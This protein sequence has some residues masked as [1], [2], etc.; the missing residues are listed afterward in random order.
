[1]HPI[2]INIKGDVNGHQLRCDFA[3]IRRL[4]ARVEYLPVCSGGKPENT[5]ETE[6]RKASRTEQPEPLLPLHASQSRHQAMHHRA[7]TMRQ[8]RR[9]RRLNLLIL[10][11]AAS[12]RCLSLRNGL[13]LQAH[14]L[15]KGA[16]GLI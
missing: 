6:E 14:Q 12:S 1:A 10:I 3:S 8:A 9:R 15:L 13:E 5:E 7:G 16:Y 2:G 11:H 4:Q